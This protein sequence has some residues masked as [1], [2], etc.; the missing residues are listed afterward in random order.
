IL[1]ALSLMSGFYALVFGIYVC[2]FG[3]SPILPWGMCQSWCLRKQVK[4]S[5]AKKYP[6]YIP[7][8]DPVDATVEVRQRIA[9]LEDFLK[10]YVVEVDV[11]EETEETDEALTA[12]EKDE[13]ATGSRQSLAPVSE[14]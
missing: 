14:E 7:L 6:K 8:I 4:D 5:L 9:Y 11:L 13:L 2:L 1:D 3:A 10:D 12:A